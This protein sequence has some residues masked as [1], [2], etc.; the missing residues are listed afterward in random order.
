[1]YSTHKQNLTTDN[2]NIWNSSI[3]FNRTNRPDAWVNRM[4]PFWGAPNSIAYLP[5]SVRFCSPKC[6]VSS[7]WVLLG[8]CDLTSS[9]APLTSSFVLMSAWLKQS[10]GSWF[11]T[12]QSVYLDTHH[13]KL[14]RMQS[15]YMYLYINHNP[16]TADH[17]GMGTRQCTPQTCALIDKQLPGAMSQTSMGMQLVR[18][19][20][21]M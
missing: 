4:Y 2:D 17:V 21:Y 3:S 18:T 9:T 16:A 10:S 1:M 11:R 7:D 6:W 14:E 8:M 19:R 13:V 20:N 15:V 12:M 5:V